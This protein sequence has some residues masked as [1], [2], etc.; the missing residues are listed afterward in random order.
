MAF[1]VYYNELF[2]FIKAGKSTLTNE[3]K[4]YGALVIDADKI[5]HEIYDKGCDAYNKMIEV[6]GEQILNDKKEIN[7]AKISEI[8]FK[9]K[10]IFPK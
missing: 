9:N 3:F 6:F 7:R 4:K 5:C 8:V 10:S 2:I 1:V